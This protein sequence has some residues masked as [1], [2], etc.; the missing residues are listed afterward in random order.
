MRRL[1]RLNCRRPDLIKTLE[2]ARA[3]RLGSKVFKAS[4]QRLSLL[5][6]RPKLS[7]P[8]GVSGADGVHLG[9]IDPPSFAPPDIFGTTIANSPLP[10]QKFVHCSCRAS[11][12][13]LHRVP[14]WS[15]LGDFVQQA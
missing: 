13:S 5:N 9:G 12:R 2:I 14:D 8:L 1:P 4:S 6:F 7:R 15:W 11:N 3:D 10:R